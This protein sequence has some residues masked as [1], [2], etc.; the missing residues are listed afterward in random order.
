MVPF[1]YSD[2][3][4]EHVSRV[5]VDSECINRHGRFDHSDSNYICDKV[6]SGKIGHLF[7]S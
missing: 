5:K 4:K 6:D 7:Y 2:M 1:L 3:V